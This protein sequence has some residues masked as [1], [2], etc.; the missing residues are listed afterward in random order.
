MQNCRVNEQES[1]G[2]TPIGLA[3]YYRHSKTTE[4]LLAE[5][6][7]P[8]VADKYRI[9]TALRMANTMPTMIRDVFD[10]LVTEDLYQG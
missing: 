3:A 6:A 8:F 4:Y 7:D 9:T 1:L 10:T 2:L 5:G